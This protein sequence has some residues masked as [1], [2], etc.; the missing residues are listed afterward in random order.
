MRFYGFLLRLY[1]ASFRAEYGEEMR[2]LF[3]RRLREAN[4]PGDTAALWLATVLDV[5][6]SAWRTHADLLRLDVRYAARAL[7]RAPG[8]AVT[9]ILVAGV[10]IGAAT[11]SYSVLDHV[12]V[13]PLPFAEA[14]RLVDLWE[15][16]T[17]HGYGRTELSPANYRDWKSA[18]RSFEGM[19]AFTN[20][21]VN[22]A[23]EG[24]P[25]RL[26]G[27]LATPDLFEVLRVR[28][29]LGRILTEAD[30]RTGAEKTVVIS[31]G[32]WRR[33]F[34]GDPSVLG[35]KVLLDDAPHVVV[36][37]MPPDFRFPAR[38]VD[39]WTPFQFVAEDFA[40]RGDCYL[41]CV[42]RLKKGVS[43]EQAR[44][45][46]R[47][48]AAR[49]ERA[50]PK[51]NHRI[52]ATVLRLRDEMA[53][54]ARLLLVALFGAA[55]GVL[56]IG[57]TN[58]A[59]LLLARAIGRRKELAVRTAMGA[60]RERLVRQLLTESMVLAF[61]GGVLGVA[62]AAA[63]GPLVTRLVP[64]ALPIA[65]NPPLDLRLLAIAAVLTAATG[66]G[67]GV[68]PALRAC[69]DCAGEGL[70][71][72]A[73]TGA[74][75]STERLRAALV[76]A[77]ITASVILLVTSGLLLRALWKLQRT[78]PGFRADGVLTMRTAL[79]SPRYEKTGVRQ[80]FYDRVLAQA[81][82]L[83]GVSHAAYIT[84][85]PI[86][87][88]GGIWPVIPEGQP[89]NGDAETASLRFVTPDYFATLG[90]PLRAGRDVSRAD[91]GQ[92]L[93]VAVVSDSF[94]RRYWPG[95][96]ALGRRF[97]FGQ[98]ERTI[99]GI[100]GDVRVRGIE[101]ESEPQVY[102]PS[103]Q[104]PDGSLVGYTPKDLVIRSSVPAG[105]LVP[106][107]RRIVAREDPLLPISD[108]R[109]LA[110]LVASDTASRRIQ[111]RMLAA[112]A[113]ISLAL[114]A[115]GIHGLLSFTISQRRREIGVRIA[116]GAMPR[117]I[118]EMVL[119]RSLLLAGAGA[120]LG[121]LLGLAA[122]RAM[123]ALLAGVRPADAAT[124]A[125]AIGLAAAMTAAGSLLPALRAV[126]IDPV[127]AIRAD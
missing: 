20:T 103:G 91:T 61:C 71:E 63:A 28:A 113:A 50:Y 83:P 101:R 10:G 54:Q 5:A 94:A 74:G 26:D 16:D 6:V 68:V 121:G 93:F 60:G 48:V 82:A 96:N 105:T 4:G 79:P 31:D 69:R 97:R 65:E 9:A 40:D 127:A 114:A 75:R 81:R 12:L 7:S 112:F 98:A 124:F 17:L 27:V 89:D 67:F 111:A 32:L 24:N 30:G 44:T 109:S 77:E 22:L 120:L 23:G 66:V 21:S 46:M 49:L 39:V 56:L 14:D 87:M 80:N 86:A 52:G 42:A 38:S 90:I 85:L 25:E 125:A 13:R 41:K 62:L 53:P 57:C 58:L 119:G 36:G 123:Q 33:R 78:D 55:A 110:D 107:V 118:V 99:V 100:V 70:Q 84:T 59:S 2:R 34:G 1:P 106:E 11:A 51:E 43:P 126:R 19:A 18:S 122:G 95:E 73:R 8:F 88:T 64:N 117:D 108:V 72:G 102:L 37:V 47:L 115:L 29:A 35:R 116:L 104:V 76:V 92:S 3:A 45:E 15:N